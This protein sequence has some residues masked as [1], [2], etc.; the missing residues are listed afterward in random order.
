VIVIRVREK[1][2]RNRDR[3]RDSCAVRTKPVAAFTSRKLAPRETSTFREFSNRAQYAQPDQTRVRSNFAGQPTR[4]EQ[5]RGIRQQA[6]VALYSEKT[7][8][9][10]AG[11]LPYDGSRFINTTVAAIWS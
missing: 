7:G 6:R 5:V 2:Y 9:T 11:R 8:M 1:S 10:I 4:S 3:G